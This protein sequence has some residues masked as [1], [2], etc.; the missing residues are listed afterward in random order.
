VPPGFTPT[1]TVPAEPSRFSQPLWPVLHHEVIERLA[2]RFRILGHAALCEA[3]TELVQHLRNGH[4]GI[5]VVVTDL[6]VDREPRLGVLGER[7][8]PDPGM[9]ST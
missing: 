6:A 5:L 2:E 4:D 7:F 1:I 9:P 3:V 8:Q